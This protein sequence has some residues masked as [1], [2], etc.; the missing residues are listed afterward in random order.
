MGKKWTMEMIKTDCWKWEV[1]QICLT[2]KLI[3]ADTLLRRLPLAMSTSIAGS[4]DS[5][6]MCGSGSKSRAMCSWSFSSISLS[7]SIHQAGTPWALTQIS[8]NNIIWTT[9]GVN[10]NVKEFKMLLNR[11]AEGNLS[12][13]FLITTFKTCM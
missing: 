11:E 1:T 2:D 12:Y 13:S 4:G 3:L 5:V 8:L 9:Q 6:W 7:S 10:Q